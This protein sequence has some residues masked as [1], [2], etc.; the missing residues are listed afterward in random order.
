MNQ[1][2]DKLNQFLDKA[3]R[4]CTATSGADEHAAYRLAEA[5]LDD[6]SRLDEATLRGLTVF[7]ALSHSNPHGARRLLDSNQPF[8]GL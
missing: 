3:R 8:A 6:A 2:Q 7:L 5:V 4:G 1:I